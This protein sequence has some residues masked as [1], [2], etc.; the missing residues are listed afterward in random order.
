M[1][2]ESK[3]KDPA[4]DFMIDRLIPFCQSIHQ[5][6]S[7]DSDDTG[8]KI[9]YTICE[10]SDEAQVMYEKYVFMVNQ[11]ADTN[12]QQEIEPCLHRLFKK[13]RHTLR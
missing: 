3:E 13:S 9:R 5:V 10:F 2:R 12:E 11:E 8:Q 7:Q 4:T 1:T 6:N